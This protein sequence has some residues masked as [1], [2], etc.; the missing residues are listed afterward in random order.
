MNF[1]CS[2][3]TLLLLLL[4]VMLLFWSNKDADNVVL[5]LKLLLKRFC[6]WLFLTC[7]KNCYYDVF[8]WNENKSN[9]Q[10]GGRTDGQTQ[11]SFDRM[12]HSVQQQKRTKSTQKS[13][14]N[15]NLPFKHYKHGIWTILTYFAFQY[16]VTRMTKKEASPHSLRTFQQRHTWWWCIMK[17]QL[18]V[19]PKT[20]IQKLNKVAFCRFESRV[21]DSLSHW[22]FSFFFLRI[23]IIMI[24]WD[25]I[26]LFVSNF[27]LFSY[28]LSMIVMLN[29][30]FFVWCCLRWRSFL[31]IAL[32]FC[33]R[34]H[35]IYFFLVRFIFVQQ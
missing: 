25:L 31:F 32:F 6:W 8:N 34:H 29:I 12:L 13:I 10:T 14:M 5:T 15:T 2:C 1:C 35:K 26:W 30:S 20:N 21:S 24:V 11:Q 33:Q 9:R 17:N 18:Q 28:A 7:R 16:N 19:W 22:H 4:L 23:K 3:W 27:H